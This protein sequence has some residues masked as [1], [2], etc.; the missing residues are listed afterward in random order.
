MKIG[1]QFYTIRDKT[2]TPEGIRASFAKMKEIGYDVVQM[3]AIGPI[4][5][6]ELRDISLEYSLPITCTHT[7]PDRVLGETDAVIKEHLIY[8]CPVIGIGGMP[9][10][11]RGSAEGAAAFIKAFSEATKRIEA[12]GL[13]FAYHN[14][15]FEFENTHE[16]LA[17]DVLI[18]DFPSLNFILDTY[19]VKYAGHDYLSYIEKIGAGRMTNVH[20]KDMKSDPKGDICPCGTGIIDFAPVVSLCDRL[21]IPNALV[22]Q[23]NAPDIGDS[24]EQMALSFKNLAPLFG[25]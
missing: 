25:K 2:R 1:A 8:G 6:E 24:F 11:Y 20:F 7:N 10:V 19:W 13:K 3:S 18:E 12:A 5:P 17:F 21:G 23:D 16:R 15:A 9:N 4:A 22:E 14:H